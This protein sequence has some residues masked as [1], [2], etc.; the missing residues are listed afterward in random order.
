MGIITTNSIKRN[1]F[2]NIL[3]EKI[4]RSTQV[5]PWKIQSWIFNLQTSKNPNKSQPII[6]R[7]Q[8]IFPIKLHNILKNSHFSLKMLLQLNLS[9]KYLKP[10]WLTP[11]IIH[12]IRMNRIN[13]S[14]IT[15]Q[16]NFPNNPVK[17]LASQDLISL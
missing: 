15:I 2:I 11:I 6:I 8:L 12:N 1:S 4:Q 14:K 16:T 3:R 5:P 9:R 10:K 13:F 7:K 17:D